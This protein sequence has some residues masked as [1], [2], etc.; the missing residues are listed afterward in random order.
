[1]IEGFFYNKEGLKTG[2]SFITDLQKTFLD[3][4]G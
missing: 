4:Q 2:F 3:C 1:M